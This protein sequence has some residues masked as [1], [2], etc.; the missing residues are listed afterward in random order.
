M[1]DIQ[2]RVAI[3]RELIARGISEDDL[4]LAPAP[5]PPGPLARHLL[6]PFS[7]GM[8]PTPVPITL[9]PIPRRPCPPPTW[10]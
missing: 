1:E 6:I 7:D 3:G 2:E 8:A 4:A 10:W 9:R 5:G